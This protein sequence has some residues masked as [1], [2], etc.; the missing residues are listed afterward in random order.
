MT[1]LAFLLAVES[2]MYNSLVHV[3]HGKRKTGKFDTYYVSR[4]E[5]MCMLQCQ[6]CIAVDQACH[7]YYKEQVVIYTSCIGCAKCIIFFA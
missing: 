1:P 4:M 5:V 7:V 2:I 3:P 6:L